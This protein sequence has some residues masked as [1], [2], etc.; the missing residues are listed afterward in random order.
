[1]A[2]TSQSQVQVCR[3]RNAPLPALPPQRSTATRE[4]KVL[5]GTETAP[6]SSAT[7][8]RPRPRPWLALGVGE[9]AWY[10][11]RSLKPADM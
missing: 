2:C 3:T 9:N 4:Q 6:A 7:Q 1:M 8:L 11:F 5:L 10:F